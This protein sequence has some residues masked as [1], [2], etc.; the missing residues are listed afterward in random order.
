MLTSA[1]FLERRP[2]APLRT[3]APVCSGSDVGVPLKYG[4]AL[5]IGLAVLVASTE[6]TAHAADSIGGVICVAPAASPPDAGKLMLATQQYRWTFYQADFRLRSEAVVTKVLSPRTASQRYDY[7]I[8]VLHTERRVL[9]KYPEM[10]CKYPVGVLPN[11]CETVWRNAYAD[12]PV[13]ASEHD[14]V[15]IDVP[16][17]T[18]TDHTFFVEVPEW[19]WVET[20]LTVSVPLVVAPEACTRFVGEAVRW[21]PPGAANRIGFSPENDGA[22]IESTRATLESNS[23]GVLAAL[24]QGIANIDATI[25]SIKASGGDPAKVTSSDDGKSVDLLALRASLVTQK[26]YARA[27][28]ARTVGELDAVAAQTTTPNAP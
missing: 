14:H 12:M 13:L 17:W 20:P 25:A 8:P 28:L 5:L 10:S 22:S 11:D 2:R 1:L 24:D 23:A 26:E 15:I 6:R 21:A 4:K 18:W 19:T 7:E 9:W 27:R 3:G 16:A